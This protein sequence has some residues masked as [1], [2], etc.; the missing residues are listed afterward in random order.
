[1]NRRE[2]RWLERYEMYKT[3][4]ERGNKSKLKKI[5]K[6]EPSSAYNVIP[7]RGFIQNGIDWGIWTCN[8]R[9]RRKRGLLSQ[10][11]IDKL[12]EIGFQWNIFKR[13]KIT[14]DIVDQNNNNCCNEKKEDKNGEQK[15]TNIS[16][17]SDEVFLQGML[18]EL[19]K[20]FHE[21]DSRI[22]RSMCIHTLNEIK[23]G[24]KD[25]TSIIFS[26]I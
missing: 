5:N 26:F 20:R 21:A 13:R 2:K 18:D 1:M 15:L 9:M 10:D 6:E 3:I 14:R 16:V 8:Q 7:Q 23:I 22:G 24:N 25:N 4:L 19:R 17:I 12:N 11:K